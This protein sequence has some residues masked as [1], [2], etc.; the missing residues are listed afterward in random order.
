MW[1]HTEAI[2]VELCRNNVKVFALAPGFTRAGFL[3]AAGQKE[4][5]F[6]FRTLMKS[7]P[8]AQEGSP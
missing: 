5:R 2:N 7:C 1:P 6:H 3:K 4:N 8:V